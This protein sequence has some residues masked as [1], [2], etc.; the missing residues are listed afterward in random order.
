MQREDGRMVGLRALEVCQYM[1]LAVMDEKGLP[2]RMP[3][4]A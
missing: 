3:S 4:S 1:V 2:Y